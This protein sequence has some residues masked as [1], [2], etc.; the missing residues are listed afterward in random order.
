M[1]ACLELA[2]H[3]FWVCRPDLSHLN[4]T[5]QAFPTAVE[6]A[7]GAVEL[8]VNQSTATWALPP[9]HLDW[10]CG[11]MR[12]RARYDMPFDDLLPILANLGRALVVER[13]ESPWVAALR[14][15]LGRVLALD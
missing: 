8:V 15:V 7:R 2:D 14:P 11:Q 12:P 6:R 1:P 9:A 4:A 5:V 13:P 3:A 10:L